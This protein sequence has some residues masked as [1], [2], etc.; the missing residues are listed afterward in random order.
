MRALLKD[1]TFTVHAITRN[2][3]SAAAEKLKAQGAVLIKADIWD[4]DSVV[5]ALQNVECVFGVTKFFDSSIIGVN[6]EDEIRQGKILVDAAK[7]TGVKL[8]IWSSL[9]SVAETSEGK[10]VNAMHT[11]NKHE[12]Y[13]YLLRSGVPH[14]SVRTG[15]FLEN[16]WQY[17][18][19]AKASDGGYELRI[20]KYSPT[21]VE[22]FIWVERDLGPMVLAL[23][24]NYTSDG[25]NILGQ[26]FYGV[27][28]VMTFPELASSLA[29][30]LGKPVKF[31]SPET[32]G[33]RDLDDMFASHSEFGAY[34]GRTLPDPRL[35]ALGVQISTMEEF[36]QEA[37]TRFL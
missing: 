2:P 4:R 19:L 22:Y 32:S 17:G 34:P 35:L 29:D 27:S 18:F 23:M 25:S 1:G 15:H 9:P 10:Y 26:I 21:S 16:L 13:K 8:F 14:A 3:T 6:E 31:I 33:S 30:A 36:L 11:E 37:R 24:K 5:K 12:I 7:E 28:T 20:P